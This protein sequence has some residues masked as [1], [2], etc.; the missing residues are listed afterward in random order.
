M[1]ARNKFVYSTSWNSLS[2]STSSTDEWFV[3]VSGVF[4]AY[5]SVDITTGDG[6]D[7]I[8][9]SNNTNTVHSGAGN[10]FVDGGKYI[11]FI[12]GGAGN[13]TIYGDGQSSI[14]FN[15]ATG[16]YGDTGETI[17]PL[18][19]VYPSLPSPPIQYVG[20]ADQ[21]FGGAGDDRI[22]GGGGSDIIYGDDAEA[23]NTG[24][25]GND[26]IQAGSGDDVVYGGGGNDMI[27]GGLGNDMLFGQAGDDQMSGGAGIDRL[28]GGSGRDILTGGLEGDFF[29]CEASGRNQTSNVYADHITD[30]TFAQGDKIVLNASNLLNWDGTLRLV[31]G[32]GNGDGW[33]L[34]AS[35]K[36]RF[37]FDTTSSTLYWDDNGA[38]K[39]GGHH[40]IAVLES[41]TSLSS[42]SILVW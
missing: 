10:D 12:H 15:P 26:W 21:L 27:W 35:D 41:V 2:E 14:T 19:Q 1:V 22:F 9:M 5:T 16:E 17:I 25:A 8:W 33:Q 11:D 18:F 3:R 40:A 39:T 4:H 6:S 29:F 36:G 20:M 13:D 32:S 38:N 31:Q 30:F 34:G 28:W 37:Y 42:S 24:P 7:M 23:Q